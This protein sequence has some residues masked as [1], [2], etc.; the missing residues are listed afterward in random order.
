MSTSTIRWS[1][2][3]VPESEYMEVQD[4]YC[5][6]VDSSEACENRQPFLPCRKTNLASFSTVRQFLSVNALRIAS[7]RVSNVVR[8]QHCPTSAEALLDT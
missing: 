4:L 6:Q 2:R 7:T 5:M 3:E 8:R 1:N